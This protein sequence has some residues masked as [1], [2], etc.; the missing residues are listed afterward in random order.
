MFRDIKMRKRNRQSGAD[1][2]HRSIRGRDFIRGVRGGSFPGIGLG[3]VLTLLWVGIF[4]AWGATRINAQN[5]EVEFEGAAEV[6]VQ[7]GVD[8]RGD[9]LLEMSGL[10][11]GG[12]PGA[13]MLPYRLT[14]I[15]LPADAELATVQAILAGA[16]WEELPGEYELGSVP[17]AATW[18]GTKPV[19]DWGSSDSS[20]IVTGRNIDIYGKD[21]YF[22][23]QAVEVVSVGKYRQWKLAEIR[24]WQAVYNPAQKRIRVLDKGGVRVLAQLGNTE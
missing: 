17:P 13:P 5:V 23:E 9:D 3:I 12:E 19:F 1:C 15:L 18:D 20:R 22:P 24:V 8:S 4:P 16:E 14:R 7:I 6:E 10:L 11:Q 2:N 21:A